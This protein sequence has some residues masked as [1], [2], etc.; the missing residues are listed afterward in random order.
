MKSILIRT[1]VLP[2]LL[3]IVSLSAY[4]QNYPLKTITIITHS[5]PG[6]GSDVFLRLLSR[7]LTPEL[8]VNIVIKNITGGSGAAAIA[9]LANST[10]DG[11][12]FYA[13]TPTFIYTS[14]LSR[15]TFTDKDVDPI[16]NLFTDPELI[17]TAANSP[18]QTLKEVLDKARD[19]RGIWGAANP[20]SL[21]RQ[22][23]ERL[24]SATGVNA[25]VISHEGGGDLMIN[26]LNGTLDIG[27]GEAQ[28]LNSQLQAGSLRLLATFSDRRLSQFPDLP[29]VQELGY[30][31]VVRKFRGIAAPKGLAPEIIDQWEQAI[32]AVLNN[33]EYKESYTADN[34]RPDYLGYI[35]YKDFI[36]DF[37]AETEDYLRNAGI[38]E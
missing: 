2:L 3:L 8:G 11:S 20:A 7:Y 23:L 5:R 18:Y 17:Y 30:D 33:P 22:A 37:V 21:E 9:E 15:P 36:A 25:A 29:T 38:I 24:K 19:S 1:I 13:T 28:E 10:P 31:V 32:Q 35:E 26:V 16:V 14:L 12:T 4:S 27:V 34:L 6:G